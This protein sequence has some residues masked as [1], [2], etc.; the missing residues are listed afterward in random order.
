MRGPSPWWSD[1]ICCVRGRARGG[2]G[3]TAGWPL[4]QSGEPRAKADSCHGRGR[5]PAIISFTHM[6]Y[7]RAG[8]VSRWAFFCSATYMCLLSTYLACSLW[9][10]KCYLGE[11][12][13]SLSSPVSSDQLIGVSIRFEKCKLNFWCTFNLQSFSFLFYLVQVEYVHFLCLFPYFP[14]LKLALT[15]KRIITNWIFHVFFPSPLPNAL[16]WRAGGKQKWSSH[17]STIAGWLDLHAR[18]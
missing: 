15:K 1:H 4:T 18:H 7:E 16:I 10:R 8:T 13:M 9:K 14:L 11:T 5:R 6:L 12:V 17:T 3:A 2:G